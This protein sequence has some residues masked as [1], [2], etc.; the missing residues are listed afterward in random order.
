MLPLLSDGV[1]IAAVNGPSSVVVSGVE[2]EVVR[3]AEE[4]AAR[5]CKTK[6]LAVSHAFHSALMEPMLEE[7]RAVAESVT[8]GQ[9]WV[10]AVS[11]VTGLAVEGE[12]STA[13]YWV[14][15]V[16][17][18][19]RFADAVGTLAGRGVTT[20]VELGP[21]AA[22]VPMGA[23][24][25]TPDGDG[26]GD[27]DE[28]AFVAVQR[29]DRDEVVE[30]LTGIGRLYARGVKVDWRAYFA[31]SSARTTD[32][33]TYAFQRKHY[34]A[35]SPAKAGDAPSLGLAD[36]EHP[37]LGA[38]VEVPGDGGRILTGRLSPA[39]QPWLGDHRLGE[40]I[41]FPATGFVELAVRAGDQ[42]G[43][44]LLEE[45]TLQAPLAL[46]EHRSTQIQVVVAA[47]D[48]A[49]RRSLSIYSRDQDAS[50]A[51]WTLHAQGVLA[52][53]ARRPEFDLAQWPP[54]GAE[55]MDVTDAYAV[56]HGRGY[57]YG[58][59]F[60]GL[61]AAWTLGEE[62]FAEI[63]LPEEAQA[64]AER[65]GLHPALLDA[66]THAALVHEDAPGGSGAVLPFAWVDVALHAAGAAAVRVRLTPTDEGIAL[67]VA[68]S[69]GRP[70]LEAGS[71]VSRPVSL[72]QLG[73]AG[74]AVHHDDLYQVE[75]HP[76]PA[77][78]GGAER[79]L[80]WA[81]W[82][83]EATGPLPDL[84]L[85]PSTPGNDAE[86]VHAR[87][88][89]VL[90]RLQSYLSDDRYA[91]TRLLVLT[92][93]AVA[94][95]G[96]DVRDL[97]GAAVWGL[98]RAAQ[99]E[100]PGR[101]LLADLE[102]GTAVDAELIAL[103][104]AGEPQVAVRGGVAHAARLARV[105]AEPVL[106]TGFDGSGTVL[107]TGASG[108]LGGLVARHLVTAHGV[109]HLVLTSRRGAAADGVPRLV[110]ELTALGADVRAVA[111]D[112][113]DREQ[114][115]AVLEGIAAEHPLTGVVH[116]AG[117]L[118]DGVIGRLTPAQVEAS[119]RAKADAVLHLHELTRDMD[120]TAFVL[121]SS[122]AGVFGNAGQAGYSAA[123]AFLDAFATHRRAN[124]LPGVSLG[125]GA[126]SRNVGMAGTLS[127]HDRQRMSRRGIDE[128]SVERGLA[129]FDTAITAQSPVVL[130]VGLDLSVL[131]LAGAELPPLL[132][133]LVPAVRRR[134]AGPAPAQVS[135]HDRLA[136]L[137]E[138]AR[139]TLL[140]RV[141]LE[142]AAD[143]LGHS[144]AD[145]VDPE[146]DFLESGF[147]SLTSLELRNGLN[148]ATGLRLSP[149]AVF[150]NKTP[151]QLARHLLA[152]LA[153]GPDAAGA[154]GRAG[155]EQPAG[156]GT[157]SLSTLLR[158]AAEAGRM[159]KGFD[160]LR[161]FADIR[162]TFGS[163]AELDRPAA[164]VRLADG[165]G[166]PRLICVSTPMATGGPAQYARL[167]A[168]F[169]G[170][171]HVSVVPLPGFVAGEPLPGTVRAAVEAVAHGVLAA[172]E[173]EP[174]VLVG[175]S[176]G[177]T[178]AHAT[179]AYLE[180]ELG[181]TAAG[182]VLLD[183][184]RM[185]SGAAGVSLDALA[186]GL[187]AKESAFG[188]FDDARLSAMAGWGRVLSDVV[189]GRLA[190]PVLLAQATEPFEAPAG[191]TSDDTSWRAQPWHPGH[192][193][194]EAR[195]NHF[196]IIEERAA[197]TAALISDWLTSVN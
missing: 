149:T 185:D 81:E 85:L 97:A 65:F 39:A 44:E 165:A 21:D 169:R 53:E 70:V 67:A 189:P 168:A 123:N 18:P 120:L 151:A 88:C 112:A 147:D 58:P 122:M 131:A 17:Q 42:V 99:L 175:Y 148:Q 138:K 20:F 98:V 16:R 134:P 115:A 38:V 125:W 27:V 107:V 163:A 1:G 23:E 106:P 52:R 146:R 183:S 173:G 124:G 54:V 178:L 103:V 63:T 10:A 75:W 150:D 121:F 181:V 33:P 118:D 64:D 46:P 114:L 172:A 92:R 47:A 135:V 84:L 139:E 37:L 196:T 36:A 11:T 170:D 136:G 77:A 155:R 48:E 154:G 71:V 8:Y 82:S 51:V 5:G 128:L 60:Q 157:G 79:T 78:A 111:A 3:V 50:D 57:G 160:L 174:F 35:H 152:E 195:A 34:W 93:G 90:E 94:R 180:S 109:R 24:C 22:L 100:N 19:V 6:R 110:E 192:H 12:W 186:H 104:T 66:A 142:Q 101:I 95:G 140:L 72:E 194:V 161:T 126:W 166:T 25:V 73:K 45:L 15:Q 13:E 190:A 116:A 4:L 145:A 2:A 132:R 187:L 117:V 130:P 158:A 61:T 89:H 179:A 197:D 91:G 102:Q 184:Y 69:A 141:V 56:L 96:E 41:L 127:D 177:G 14:D 143:V 153:A 164:P 59:V 182:V 83:D 87:T 26:D 29:R 137:D 28:V 49:G 55:P 105:P 40:T 171:R 133:G 167:A 193:V 80:S 119:L 7:F 113:G 176:S 191:D 43:C 62:V 108:T 129:L 68:D 30:L 76:L 162:P 159:D 9:A 86:A 144:G 156:G 32:L 74:A 188:G 31:G